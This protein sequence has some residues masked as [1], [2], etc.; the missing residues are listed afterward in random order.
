MIKLGISFILVGK[1]TCPILCLIEISM[2]SKEIFPEFGL[3]IFFGT[4]IKITERSNVNS[5]SKDIPD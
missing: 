2:G 3:R 1:I 4:S 5:Y